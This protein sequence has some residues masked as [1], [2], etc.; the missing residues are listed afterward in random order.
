MTKFMSIFAL[1]TLVGCS[2]AKDDDTASDSET[3][4]DVAP[5]EEEEEEEEETTDCTNNG[6][7]A[8]EA[9]A[10]YSDDGES[11]WFMQVTS[12]DAPFTYLVMG[13]EN[14]LSFDPGVYDLSEYVFDDGELAVYIGECTDSP[15]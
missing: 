11:T 12:A 5:G 15:M 2:D 6:F 10:V 9:S 7:A 8:A 1:A 14:R 13:S 4:E 3:T